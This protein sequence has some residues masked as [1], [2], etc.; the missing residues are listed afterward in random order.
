MSKLKLLIRE[1]KKFFFVGKKVLKKKFLKTMSP[2]S[3][4]SLRTNSDNNLALKNY[5][6]QK[7][8]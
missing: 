2:S 6:R 5:C 1:R 8:M 4:F 7:K 3:S